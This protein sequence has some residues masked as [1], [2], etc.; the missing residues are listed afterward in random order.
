VKYS[1]KISYSK[2]CRNLPIISDILLREIIMFDISNN[3][4]SK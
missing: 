1:K 3:L 4:L 2:E